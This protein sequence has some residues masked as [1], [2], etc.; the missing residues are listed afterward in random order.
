MH[1]QDVAEN[2]DPN[3]GFCE[4]FLNLQ[5]FDKFL[6]KFQFDY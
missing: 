2:F 5:K 3:Y 6:L 4:D 1:I